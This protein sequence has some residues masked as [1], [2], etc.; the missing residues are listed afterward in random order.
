VSKANTQ[1]RLD[2]IQAAIQP[3]QRAAALGSLYDA[4][5]Q[6]KASAA[7]VAT[8]GELLSSIAGAR[9]HVTLLQLT[10]ETITQAEFDALNHLRS[11]EPVPASVAQTI[12]NEERLYNASASRWQDRVRPDLGAPNA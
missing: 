1:K 6:G 7:D 12:A 2:R 9:P 3:A 11:G 5:V 10:G 8:F 4:A